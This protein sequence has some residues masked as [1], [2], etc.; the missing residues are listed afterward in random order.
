MTQASKIKATILD[1]YTDRM[2]AEM[3]DF[4]A[5]DLRMI[6]NASLDGKVAPG[7]SDRVLRMLRQGGL[8]NYIVL[9][10]AQSLYRFIPVVSDSVPD[11][12]G[13]STNE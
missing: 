9:N 5:N 11:A 4:T 6:V 13:D 2:V 1:F 8:L 3:R 12:T 7:S 10:R